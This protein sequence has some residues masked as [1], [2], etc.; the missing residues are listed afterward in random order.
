VRNLFVQK[1]SENPKQPQYQIRLTAER[2]L[3]SGLSVLPI[4]ADGVKKPAIPSWKDLET[5]LP[6]PADISS[7]FPP[8]TK[9]GI[10]IACGVGSGGLEVFDFEGRFDFSEFAAELEQDRPGLLTRLVIIKTPS[11][12]RHLYTKWPKDLKYQPRN[13]KLAQKADPSDVDERGN[14][15]IKCLIE[16]RAA[17]GYV[18]APG[19]PP[20]C[21][22]LQ[23]PY[24]ILQGNLE[25]IPTISTVEREA[26]IRAARSFNEHVKLE[27]AFTAKMAAQ[28]PKGNRPGDD[29]NARGD[30]TALLERHGWRRAG[31]GRGGERWR[32]PKGERPS[33]TL[34]PSGH[35]YVFSTNA[36]PFEADRAYDPFAIYSKLEHNGDFAA[37]ARQLGKEG[38]GQEAAAPSKPAATAETWDPPAEFYKFDLPAFPINCLPDSLKSFVSSLA[39]ATQTPTDL[40][41]VLALTVCAAA[42]APNV[43]VQARAGWIEPPNLMTLGVLPPG[44]RKTAV[45]T[46]AISPLLEYEKQLVEEERDYIAEKESEYR[47]LKASL[48]KAE[49]DCARLTGSELVAKDKDRKEL[50][51]K[52]ANFK[53]PAEPRLICQD[54]TSEELISQL[55]AQGGS[56]GLFSDEGGIFDTMAGRYQ[57]GAPNIDVY[58]QSHSGSPLRVNRRNRAEFIE[59]PTLTVGLTVQPEIISSLTEKP[60]FRGRGLLAR[61]LY[62]SPISNMGR[63]KSRPV[64]L[65]ADVRKTYSLLITRLA[66]INKTLDEQGRPR[67][68]LL[69]LSDAA[70]DA[71]AEFQDELEPDLGDGGNLEAIAD[72]A[73]KLPGAVVRIAGVLHLAEAK[74]PLL[75]EWPSQIREASMLDAIEIGRYFTAHAVKAFSLMGA[76]PRVEGAKYIIGRLEEWM[77]REGKLAITRQELWQLVRGR[78]KQM[79]E[80]LPVLDLLKD[81]DY[82][83]ATPPPERVG[84]RGGRPLT[85]SYSLNPH[86]GGPK[87]PKTPKTGHQ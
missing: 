76:D 5:R 70:D 23:K 26:I 33:A 44:H 31:K 77:Q 19:S 43:R 63:R 11:G 35:L 36:W 6:S 29:Y 3:Q 54:V 41:A 24:E 20:H 80:L 7:W 17:G 42:I 1:P 56:I 87:T 72:W 16:T 85:D 40:A 79:D 9:N 61:F 21:H 25:E 59:N 86:L 10:G 66:L 84:H 75:P 68:R 15:K 78:F 30:V 74:P 49:K 52:L 73:S 53:V 69:V 60:G 81:H 12:G 67:P 62:S 58:L 46:Q 18:L 55:V 32:R 47:M 4:S 65:T 82:I 28:D 57:S 50:A 27:K 51:K 8:D 14:P 71:L 34:F 38:Y 48:E 22:P 83:R 64:P 2:Y 39:T 37:A 45:H 13:Q